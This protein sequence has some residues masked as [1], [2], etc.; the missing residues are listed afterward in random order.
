MDI[1]PL[2]YASSLVSLLTNGI[3]NIAV[4]DTSVLLV[5]MVSTLNDSCVLRKQFLKLIYIIN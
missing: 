1:I 5:S 4:S 2:S 3:I